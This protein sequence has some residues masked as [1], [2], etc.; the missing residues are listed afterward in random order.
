MQTYRQDQGLPN[1]TPWTWS[2][3][4]KFFVYLAIQAAGARSDTLPRYPAL[5][6][7]IVTGISLESVRMRAF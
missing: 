6:V 5:C 2:C 1:V 3:T 7:E 4:T